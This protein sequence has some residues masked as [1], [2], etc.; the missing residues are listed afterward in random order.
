M[1]NTVNPTAPRNDGDEK[2]DNGGLDDQGKPV[3][4]NAG[5]VQESRDTQKPREYQQ[6]MGKTKTPSTS[7]AMDDEEVDHSAENDFRYNTQ[8]PGA[9]ES[10]T[11]NI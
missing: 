10:V 5:S 7:P 11:R 2:S 1:N 8:K 6:D 3:K 4:V 9:D